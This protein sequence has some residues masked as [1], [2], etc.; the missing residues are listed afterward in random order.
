MSKFM[1]SWLGED[2]RG[3]FREGRGGG[4]K[5]FFVICKTQNC[6]LKSNS[7]FHKSIISNY[8]NIHKLLSSNNE[9]DDNKI[10]MDWN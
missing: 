3:E 2:E 1:D 5:F 9:L 8:I 6:I 4:D 10:Q 7:S